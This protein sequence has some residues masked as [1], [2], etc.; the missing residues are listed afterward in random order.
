MYYNEA[1]KGAGHGDDNSMIGVYG[2]SG[3]WQGIPINGDTIE[4][5]NLISPVVKAHITS[6]FALEKL[7][8][9]V[10]S[11]VLQFEQGNANADIRY[12]GGIKPGDTTAYRI[13]GLVKITDAS[14]NYLPR[15]LQ[16]TDV[17]AS[18]VFS[19]DNLYFRNINLHSRNSSVKMEGDALHFLRLYFTSPEKITVNWK[20]RSPLINLNDFIGLVGKRKS[21]APPAKL[22]ASV[23]RFSSQL[24][25]V[26][27]ESSISLDAR[28]D[29]MVYKTFVSDAVVA[30]LTLGQAGI[31]LQEVQINQGSGSVT[32]SGKMD[33]LAANNPFNLKANVR[34]VAVKRLFTDFGNFGQTA[35]GA[36]NLEGKLTADADIHGLMSDGG[37]IVKNSLKGT[38]HFD[39]ED[40]SINNFEPFLKVSRFAFKNRNLS[41]IA[42]R[43][44]KG[45]LDL[46]G[47]K[48]FIPPLSIE[49]SALNMNVQGVY[50]LGGGTDIYMVIPLRNPEKEAAKTL[51]GKLIRSG[52]GVV[53]HL[54]AQDVDGTGVDIGWDPLR[55]GKEATDNIL[56]R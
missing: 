15:N 4:A 32:I 47:N 30:R 38:V 28:L 25:K 23:S 1:V 6:S 43:Q 11:D 5:T 45:T 49:T 33:Q 21:A 24:N 19:G 26:L 9:T 42:V 53:L 16:F 17:S 22:R 52:K 13:D 34:N 56:A 41:A 29:K 27:D 36:Q 44:L 8:E 3:N 12:T 10:G 54:R 35:I 55:H 51:F 2:L 37:V 50:G 18:L 7:N 14:L 20:M 39:L 48:I 31:F 40:G 46:E